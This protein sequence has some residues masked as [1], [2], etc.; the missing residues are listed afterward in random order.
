MRSVSYESFLPIPGF[1]Y[2]DQR[3]VGK[4]QAGEKH[5]YQACQSNGYQYRSKPAKCFLLGSC[6]QKNDGDIP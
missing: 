6:A 4:K 3:F 1:F 2:G 5:Q